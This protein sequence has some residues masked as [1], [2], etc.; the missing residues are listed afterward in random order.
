MHATTPV[1]GPAD[2]P[3]AAR[4]R[5]AIADSVPV[6]GLVLVTGLVLR[7]LLAFV[8]FPQSGSWSDISQLGDWS[9]VLADVGPVDF[10]SLAGAADPTP[11]TLVV[12]WVLGVS[13]KLV[14]IVTGGAAVEII[15]VWIKMPAI[16]ADVLVA[17]VFYRAIRRWYGPPTGEAWG[18]LVAAAYLF[19]P[20]T[21]YDSALWGQVDAIGV[22]LAGL[23]LIWLVD[24][25]AEAAAAAATAAALVEP[26]LAFLLPVV[27]VVL[28]RRHLHL[29]RPAP[30]SDDPAHAPD[31]D[32]PADRDG[33]E[34]VQI[35][36]A[37]PHPWRPGCGQGLLDGLGQQRQR[38]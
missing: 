33:P 1:T 28:V 11:G 2:R 30:V 22:L 35:Q 31:G 18:A 10:Y 19:V 6:I 14:A 29:P 9:L 12:L 13:A 24:R 37:D 23:T 21:W 34:D 25:R 32:H 7:L 36:P 3:A 26:R 17:W 16:V 15:P 8:V 5:W 38:R 20:V 27:A 4:D